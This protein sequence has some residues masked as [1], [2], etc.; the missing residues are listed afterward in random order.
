[1]NNSYYAFIK[2]AARS[3]DWET[4]RHK[5]WYSPLKYTGALKSFLDKHLASNESDSFLS[6][7]IK[8]PANFILNDLLVGTAHDAFNM[9]DPWRPLVNTWDV[10][11]GNIS[12]DEYKGRLADAAQSALWTALTIPTAI[13]TAGVAAAPMATAKAA[14]RKS[15]TKIPFSKSRAAY[16]AIANKGKNLNKELLS[17][18]TLKEK[19]VLLDRAIRYA[20][21]VYPNNPNAKAWLLNSIER[22]GLSDLDK[23]LLREASKYYGLFNKANSNL[24]SA[25]SNLN[26]NYSF[27]DLLRLKDP[28]IDKYVKRQALIN[29]LMW[30]KPTQVALLG[31]LGGQLA[32]LDEDSIPMKVFNAPINLLEAPGRYAERNT[33]LVSKNYIND[34]SK[35]IDPAIIN[36][37]YQKV[38]GKNQYKLN[39]KLLDNYAKMI[40]NNPDAGLEYKDAYKQLHDIFTPT[41]NRRL[42]F[43]PLFSQGFNRAIEGK[44]M[45]SMQSISPSSNDIF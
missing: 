40:S 11:K 20:D 28:N 6:K 10:L 4:D 2:R 12:K 22:K 8:R 21:K 29:K 35:S 27:R 36:Q 7:A 38:P 18:K 39:T 13:G 17:A 14:L 31:G 23:N 1:M 32:G 43:M 44:S 3:T 45:P 37:F 16:K 26:K 25:A 41:R 42:T 5:V 24:F 15:L 9:A 33:N 19:Q 30:N 34:L